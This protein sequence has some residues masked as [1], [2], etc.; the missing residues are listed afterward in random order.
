MSASGLLQADPLRVP[1]E[2]NADHV[3]IIARVVS[4]HFSWHGRDV[5]TAQVAGLRALRRRGRRSAGPPRRG[6]DAGDDRRGVREKI[7][8]VPV[9]LAGRT[10]NLDSAF[11]EDVSIPP[12][13]ARPLP[14]GR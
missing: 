9:I 11:R 1:Q 4:M 8:G 2:I 10:R 3:E 5:S 6:H 7:H 14:A 12:V 13:V